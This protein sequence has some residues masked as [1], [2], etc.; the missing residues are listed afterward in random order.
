MALFTSPEDALISALSSKQHQ[1]L[2]EHCWG[3][4]DG[5]F[6]RAL[7]KERRLVA[8]L[9]GYEARYVKRN[10]IQFIFNYEVVM[11]YQDM[12][13]DCIDDVIVDNGGWNA[14][15]VLTK[16]CPQKAI[17][18]S[19]KPSEIKSKLSDIQEVM[20]SRYEGIFGWQ[21]NTLALEDLSDDVAC[22]ISYNYIIP[23][24]QLRQLQGKAMF[25]AK[26]IWD[27]ILGKAK[28]PQFVMPFLAF[29]YLTQECCYD[30]RAFDEVEDDPS[31][32]PSDPIPHL[33]YGPLVEERGICDGLAWAFKTLMDE[34]NIK[35]ICIS[36]YLKDDMKTLHMWNL[37]EMSGQYYH[38]DPT[39]GIKENG[40]D[41][42]ALMQP[43]S[44]MKGTHI[45]ENTRY[46]QAHG[47]RFE[48]DF[49]EDFLAK[50]GSDFL[51]DGAET[52]YFFP[53]HIIE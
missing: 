15:S 13:P 23:Q 10:F 32:L 30:Q 37:V 21:V 9:S 3:S 34:A 39:W 38:V 27:K 14:D 4:L 8:F 53:N 47:M 22:D 36:G 42:G 43:D 7:K 18:I 17:I 19:Q 1:I 51:N 50:N 28:V 12:C 33:A 16:G 35:C 41:I 20:L 49:I 31:R 45:W 48:Y 5:I 11:S 25:A 26:K 46:P 2:L 6:K 40:V 24:Q 44:M 29:S 52:K